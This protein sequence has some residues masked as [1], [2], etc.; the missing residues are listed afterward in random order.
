M[1]EPS[2]RTPPFAEVFREHAGYVSRA[3]SRLGV[4]AADAD[5]ALQ[6]VFVVVF[7]R[8]HEFE[9]RARLRT[10]LY[11]IAFRVASDRR[12]LAHVRREV[13]VDVDEPTEPGEQE[14]REDLRRACKSLDDALASLDRDK[15][16]VFVLYEIEELP[17]DEVARVVGCPLKTAYTR[18]YAA[19]DRIRA[20]LAARRDTDS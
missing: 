14:R 10:W 4:P 5:D 19:R 17:M 2:P 16:D 20:M 3:L 15:R 12:R 18:F 11:A 9:H 6:D 1:A 13:A 8:M 7:R